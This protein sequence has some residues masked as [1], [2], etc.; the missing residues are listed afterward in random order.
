[1]NV[2]VVCSYA[3]WQAV[4]G[5]QSAQSGTRSTQSQSRRRGRRTADSNRTASSA[6]TAAVNTQSNKYDS[7]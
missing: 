4:K 1:M 3:E 6:A 5:Q 7:V 2:V